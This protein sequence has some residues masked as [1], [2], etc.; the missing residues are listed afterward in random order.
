[1]KKLR[2]LLSLVL[3]VAMMLSIPTVSMAASTTPEKLN[4]MGLLLNISDSELDSVLTREVGLTMILKSLGYT[5]ADADSVANNGYFT[6]VSGWSKGWA[7]LA[8]REGITTGI[9]N[10]KFNPK[11][12]LTEKQFVAFQLRGLKYDTAAAWTDA[13]LLA[14]ASGLITVNDDLGSSVYTKRQASDIM[15][16]A[17]SSKLQNKDAKLIDELIAKSVVTSEKATKYALTTAKPVQPQPEK[18]VDNGTFK[19]ADITHESLKLL[20][21][22]FTKEIDKDTITS[23]NIEVNVDGSNLSYD[24]TYS[25]GVSPGKYGLNIVDT[26]TVDIILGTPGNQ[27]DD[28]IIKVDDVKS[29]NRDK[30]DDYKETVKLK[31]IID[32]YIVSVVA[33]NPK[34]IVVT[35]NEP[36]QIKVGSKL[37]DDVFLDGKRLAATGTLTPDG[38]VATFELNE[39]MSA[40]AHDFKIKPQPDFANFTTAEKTVRFSVV[41]DSSA[42]KITSAE[43]INK[44]E[45]VITFD[46]LINT[47]RGYFEILGSTYRLSN[48]DKVKVKDKTVT[49]ELSNSLDAAAAFRAV[50]GKFKD[51]EDVIGNVVKDEQSFSFK[52]K[53]DLT[54][55]TMD[56]KVD[57]SNHII[58]TFSEAVQSF[59][60][61]NVKIKDS[62]DNTISVS[63]VKSK[64]GSKREFIITLTNTQVDSVEYTVTIEGVKDRSVIQNTMAK[65][66]A[67]V[68]LDD[69]VQPKV[70]SVILIDTDKVRVTFS[71]PMKSDNLENK[72]YYM[73]EDDSKDTTALLSSVDKAD[74]DA[75]S[76]LKSVVLTIPGVTLRD[77][78][79][80]L[81]LQDQSGSI[82]KEYNERLL[83]DEPADFGVTDL[84][85]E[86]VERRKI[87]LT[88]TKHSFKV[89]FASDF[90]LLNGSSTSDN[91][92]VYRAE[93]DSKDPKIAYITLNADLDTDGKYRGTT[94]YLYTKDTPSTTDSYGQALKISKTSPL[95]IKDGLVPTVTLD[96]SV[97]DKLT[98]KFSEKMSASNH[99]KIYNDV[100][101]RTEDGKFIE[102]LKGDNLFYKGAGTDYD[103]FES[104]EITKLEGGKRYSL[105]ILSRNIKD[106]QNNPVKEF[107]NSSFEIKD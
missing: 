2:S 93:V 44:D 66:S 96:L 22:T 95:I 88:S 53:E 5:Q 56:V 37:Y 101:L 21:I 87:K 97:S 106:D 35:F 7:E 94:Q 59:D 43:A 13:V 49:I 57:S 20:T 99:D 38:K 51:I 11:G 107:V 67:K 83:I 69:K 61:S 58:V 29:V 68:K 26:K 65:S 33:S 23:S 82:L 3:A 105:T 28:V 39:Q 86:L 42:P 77:K 16:N 41:S 79:R 30:I 70:I 102:L 6:D 48:T 8:Y 64:E 12:T 10:N 89:I 92:Y 19:V 34:T 76:D 84:T 98:I 90:T 9:G 4:D 55:P 14:K 25:D 71:E 54:P 47:T 46:E 80:I 91:H 52:A 15:F 50:E 24:S 32:P 100:L 31:D 73:F 27:S 62:K 81:H 103:S 36:V 72:D 45:L 75:D 17:L 104:L 40:G 85:A 78:I 18:P 1:M 74:V 60:S 63:T